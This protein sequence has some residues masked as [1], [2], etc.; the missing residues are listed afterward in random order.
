ME[1]LE[2]YNKAMEL[3]ED[4]KKFRP[5]IADNGDFSLCVVVNSNDEI[6]AGVTGI[7]ISEGKV[8]KACSEYNALMSMLFDGHIN[9]K[10]MMT[11]S[12]ADGSICRPCSECMDMLYKADENN[13]QCEIAVTREESVKAC[14]LENMQTSMNEISEPVNIHPPVEEVPAFS[15]EPISE[16]FSFEEK[17]GFDFDDT[18]ATPVQ[19]LSP[20]NSEPENVQSEQPVNP[21]TEQYQNIPQGMNPQFVQPNN[22]PAYTQSQGYPYQQQQGYPQG[23]PY[24]QQPVYPQGYPYPQ[25]PYPQQNNY[26]QPNNMNPQFVQPD[27][28]YGYSQQNYQPY[29]Q[30]PVQS[31]NQGNFPYNNAQPYP[32]NSIS[33]SQPLQNVSPHQSAPYASS[34]S[35]TIGS[36]PLSGEGK[37]KFRQRLNKFMGEESPVI[38]PEPVRKSAEESLSKSEIKKLARDKKK[39]AKVNADFKKRMKDLGY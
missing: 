1:L 9:A 31:A 2:L 10:Q 27:M 35:H 23:Y 8:I 13:T 14:E 18:P 26:P 34:R 19:T 28:Q 30:Q 25:Q 7:R 22:M 17:F 3:V 38:S 20:Q 21:Y 32:Q 24:P 15:E 29:G 39:M 37:S 5:Q 4:V 6:Y 12:V 16:S 11:V 33:N 36:V